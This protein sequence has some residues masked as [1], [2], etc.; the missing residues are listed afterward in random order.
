[1]IDQYNQIKRED[2]NRFV[3]ALKRINEKMAKSIDVA[4]KNYFVPSCF[5]HIVLTRR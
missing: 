4:T 5:S 1:M 2:R 3:Q